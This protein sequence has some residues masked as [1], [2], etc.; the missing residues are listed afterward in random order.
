[1]SIMM[2]L[3]LVVRVPR[4]DN[5][6]DCNEDHITLERGRGTRGREKLGLKLKMAIVVVIMVMVVVVVVVVPL[7]ALG[8]VEWK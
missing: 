2:L 4:F 7:L 5:K 1:M 6:I 8:M 3:R